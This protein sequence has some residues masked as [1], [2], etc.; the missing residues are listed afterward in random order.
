MLM[1]FKSSDIKIKVLNYI[2]SKRKGDENILELKVEDAVSD[3][4]ISRNDLDQAVSALESEGYLR[5]L[6]MP[7]SEILIEEIK[8]KLARLDGLLLLGE[9][10]GNAY[11]KMREEALSILTR[12]PED[13]KNFSPISVT[14]IDEFLENIRNLINSLEKLKE[15]REEAKPE[16][17]ED[18]R[19]KYNKIMREQLETLSRILKS[20]S[21]TAT[22]EKI[23]LE[24]ETRDLEVL[25]IDE[26]IRGVNLNDEKEK[27]RQKINEAKNRLRRIYQV[28]LSERD[29]QTNNM[30]SEKLKEIERKLEG[31]KMRLDVLNAKI[32]IEGEKPNL[33]NLKRGLENEKQALELEIKRIRS[34]KTSAGY[35]LSSLFGDIE[36]LKESL[37]LLNKENRDF[38]LNILKDFKEI[39]ENLRDLTT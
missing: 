32:I 25:E 16:V 38:I 36:R 19:V 28:L 3:L 33:L 6:K 18:L 35:T 8:S 2:L 14:S 31:L 9:I 29:K 7:P 13:L 12:I 21:T 11:A 26:K 10:S 4:G 30:T 22:Y 17:L 24:K 39:R 5:V 27:K 20:L 34:E 37:D 23:T 1:S 15:Y